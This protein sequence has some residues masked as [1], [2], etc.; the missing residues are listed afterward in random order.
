MIIDGFADRGW[1]MIREKKKEMR[2]F[3]NTKTTGGGRVDLWRSH[4]MYAYDFVKLFILEYRQVG[5]KSEPQFYDDVVYQSFRV[6][7][8]RCE[9]YVIS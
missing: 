9:R 4:V 7:D 1:N 6:S 2:E 8:V 5:N 3:K